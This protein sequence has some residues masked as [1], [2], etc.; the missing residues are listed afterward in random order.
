[1]GEGLADK[2]A[3]K[4][5]DFLRRLSSEEERDYRLAQRCALEAIPGA[6]EL[7]AQEA[8]SDA[9]GAEVEPPRVV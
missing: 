8:P 2:A 6:H 5:A 9:Q 7:F 1:M 4:S 3:H